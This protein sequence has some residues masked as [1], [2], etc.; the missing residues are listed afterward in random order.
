MESQETSPSLIQLSFLT[1]PPSASIDHA[2]QL[3]TKA[4]ESCVLIVENQ[5]LLGIFTE[6]DVVKNAASSHL[7][8]TLV[9]ADIMTTNLITINVT[10]T[11]EIFEISRLLSAK[12]IRH[13]PV[14][15]NQ[16][17]L[18]GIVTP[19][20]IRNFLGPEHLLRYVRVS[21][22][23]NQ[24]VITGLPHESIMVLTQKMAHHCISCVV[25]IDPQIPT[26][27]GIITER[28]IVR[29]HQMGINLNQAI[30]QDVMSQPLSTMVPQES[31]WNVNQR[32]KALNV[33]R[34][35]IAHPS[36][37]LA[38][39]VT[40]SQMTKILD[41]AEMY[42]VMEQMQEI[43]NRQTNHLKQ[44]NQK[45][46]NAN[47]ELTHLSTIDALTQ[48]V[49]RRKFNEFIVDE[50][51]RLSSLQQ[52]LSLIMCDI[53]HFKKYNDMYGHLAGDECLKKVA[54]AIREIT[55]KNLD[56][57]ARYGGE[58]FAVVLSNTNSGGAEHV[59]NNILK[60]IRTLQIPFH[61]SN[62]ACYVTISLGVATVIPS[63]DCSSDTLLQLADQQLYQAKQ[64][65]RNTYAI[66][67]LREQGTRESD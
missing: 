1:L 44:L 47:L 26:P 64:N 12:K 59:A 49:N 32:M 22:V 61:L 62:K 21:D 30:A 41:P 11:Q 24:Q 9:L 10:E 28:D 34:L 33:R 66:N 25:I 53:D 14:L 58:E 63:L 15:D 8:Q 3:M 57:V 56:L 13:L 5:K 60:Q 16:N 20:S 4:K 52:P 55:R 54:S 7:V 51:K 39:L 17:Q 67:D 38:G 31:L 2:I 48:I 65:G 46:K 23:M 42:H 40:Q 29:F 19:Q 6:R 45:L 35:V 36:G 37:E 50:W 27:I 43:I 18:V